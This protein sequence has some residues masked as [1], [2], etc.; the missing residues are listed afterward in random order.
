MRS[1]LAAVIIAAGVGALVAS[2]AS[3]A[4]ASGA[5]IA[6]AA[7]QTDYVTDV[8]GGCGRWWF[9]NRWGRCVPR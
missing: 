5:P 7:Q 9:S 1:I 2:S 4:P 3:A 8:A 6:K